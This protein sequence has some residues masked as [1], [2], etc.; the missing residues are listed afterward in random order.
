LLALVTTIELT[1]E[2]LKMVIQV[3]SMYCKAPP[4]AHPCEWYMDGS[5][6]S[7]LKHG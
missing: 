5:L 4:T 1:L 2:I 6:A 7:T 3:N